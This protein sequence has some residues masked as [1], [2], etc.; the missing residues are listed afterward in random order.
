MAGASPLGAAQLGQQAAVLVE[1]QHAPRARLDVRV[2]RQP[3]RAGIALAALLDARRLAGAVE[4]ATTWYGMPSE[5]L[6]SAR[7]RSVSPMLRTQAA[8]SGWTGSV[9]TRW[10]QALSAGKTR[11]ARRG[12]RRPARRLADAD[13]GE[14]QRKRTRHRHDQGTH[15]SPML[16]GHRSRVA[17]THAR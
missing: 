11:Q 1:H 3:I 10:F 6:N 16:G 12:G 9:S 14:Q 5:A 4:P 17:I 8:E 15:G 2:V 13:G 7:S